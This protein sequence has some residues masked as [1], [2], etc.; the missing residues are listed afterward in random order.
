LVDLVGLFLHYDCFDRVVLDA[1]GDVVRGKVLSRRDEDYAV[2]AAA[3]RSA[4]L[5]GIF[6]HLVPGFTNYIIVA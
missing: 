1:I 4:A 3:L 6:R 2:A 5:P